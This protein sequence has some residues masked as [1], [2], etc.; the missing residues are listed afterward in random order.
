[1]ASNEKRRQKSLQK[2]AAKRKAKRHAVAR[3]GGGASP[4]RAELRLVAEWPLHEC[5]IS[6]K[7][8]EEGQLAQ[9]VVARRGPL[10]NIAAGS[11]LVDLGCLGVK[12]AFATVFSS[13][14][15][16]REQLRGPAEARMG[17]KKAD[18][19]LA[20]RI[21]REAIAYARS[22]GFS[23]HPDYYDAAPLL[24]AANPDAEKKKIPVGGKDGKP[25]YVAG[26][27]DD[28]TSVM[29]KLERAV[30]PNG[31]HFMAPFEAFTGG[32]PQGARTILDEHGNPVEIE[33]AG[34][35]DLDLDEE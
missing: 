18:V 9:I 19:N 23:P 22:L 8:D 35:D 3:V 10:G 17:M 13:E 30:G 15:V 28:V 20:A 5:L 26:P 4:E 6:K 16:Y 31:F 12:D 11:F 34:S 2:H 14:S 29:A 25:L 1:M 27:Y 21:V 7:W 32:L 33:L 24:A